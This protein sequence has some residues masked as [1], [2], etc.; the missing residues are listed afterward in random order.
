MIEQTTDVCSNDASQRLYP[1]R[2]QVLNDQLSAQPAD[3]E[4]NRDP[5]K[6]Q[7]RKKDKVRSAWISFTGRIVAQIVGA[8]ATVVLG[9]AVLHKYSAPDPGAR[10]GGGSPAARSPSFP[11]AFRV[12]LASSPLPS[13]RSTTFRLT[14]SRTISPMA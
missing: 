4:K 11:R 12:L 8:A 3:S 5:D 13:S 9:V 6:K 14:P 1:W 10:P 7:K 2:Q